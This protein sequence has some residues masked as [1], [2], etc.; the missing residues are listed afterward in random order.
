MIRKRDISLQGF[1]NPM[2]DDYGS[3]SELFQYTGREYSSE[4]KCPFHQGV[5]RMKSLLHKKSGVI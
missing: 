4:S 5:Q 3:T 1:I 2:V